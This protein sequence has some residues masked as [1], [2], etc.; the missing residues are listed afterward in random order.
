MQINKLIIANLIL[1]VLLFVC[2]ALLQAKCSKMSSAKSYKTSYLKGFKYLSFGENNWLFRDLDFKLQFSVADNSLSILSDINKTLQTHDIT[3]I[4]VPIPTRGLIHHDQ[5]L[6]KYD[7]TLAKSNYIRYLDQLR[8][9]GL[10]VPNIESLFTYQQYP[11]FFKGDHHWNYRGSREM[12]KLVAQVIKASDSYVDL[13]KYSFVTSILGVNKMEGSLQK[14][15]RLL[16]KKKLG[17]ESHKTYQ[18]MSTN[19]DLF[20]TEKTDIAIVGTSNSNGKIKLNFDGFI[21]HYSK[22]NTTNYALSGG[23]YKKSITQF[24]KLNADEIKSYRYIVWE[25][26]SY[27]VI[28]DKR[29]LT[30]ILNKVNS[31]SVN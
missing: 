12:A 17:K 1:L 23:G 9:S 15:Y 11:L 25:F 31:F 7:S 4:L 14:A 2:S 10:L 27:Y 24:F 30:D 8:F 19:N 20:V 13:K 28:N 29:F 3:L 26:P 5:V 21:S 22:L 16:C 18:T 6:A